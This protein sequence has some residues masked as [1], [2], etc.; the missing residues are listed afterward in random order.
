MANKP[1]STRPINDN[2]KLMREK[3]YENVTA[4]SDLLDKLGERLLTLELAIPGCMRLRLNL[5]A[6]TRQRCRLTQHS[7]PR[8][9]F[10]FWHWRSLFSIDA[11]KMESGPSILKQD[12]KIL[13]RAGSSSLKVCLV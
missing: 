11:H 7:T 2:E 13:R 9:F 4:Q 8:S 10:G 3:F 5:S 6:G 12:P 1:I